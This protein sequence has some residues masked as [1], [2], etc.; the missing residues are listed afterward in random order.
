MLSP[1]RITSIV[2][3]L[4]AVALPARAQDFALKKIDRSLRAAAKRGGEKRQ[5]IVTV[6]PGYRAD[7]RQALQEHGDLV[8]AESELVNALAVELHTE[9]VAELARHPWVELVS[10][11]AIVHV[12]SSSNDNRRMARS[13][14]AARTR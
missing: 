4:L 14:R 12:A 5:V 9:D 6:K 2:A 3:L 1:L 10:D 13:V 8:K 7:I 11:D